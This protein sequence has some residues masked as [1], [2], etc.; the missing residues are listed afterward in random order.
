MKSVRRCH[1]RNTESFEKVVNKIAFRCTRCGLV[2]DVASELGDL[3]RP[4]A[5]AYVIRL[6]NLV[7]SPLK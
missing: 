4:V 7:N 5:A 6:H 2:I 3:I 1:V